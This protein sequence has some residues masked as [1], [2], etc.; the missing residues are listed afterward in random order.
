M[1]FK[2]KVNSQISNRGMDSTNITNKD[3]DSSMSNN[4]S[5][6]KLKGEQ[7]CY[8]GDSI[9]HNCDFERLVKETG[10]YLKTIKAY[11]SVRDEHHHFPNKNFEYVLRREMIEHK[12]SILILQSSSVDIHELAK[13]DDLSLDHKEQEAKNSSYNMLRHALDATKNNKNLK[14]VVIN[15]RIPCYDGKLKQHLMQLGNDELYC[16]GNIYKDD[17]I[18]IGKHELRCDNNTMHL[19]YG[20]Y[21]DAHYDG[22][23]LKGSKGKLSYTISVLTVLREILLKSSLDFHSSTS[24]LTTDPNT[25]KLKSQTLKNASVKIQSNSSAIHLDSVSQIKIKCH[26]NEENGFDKSNEKLQY[27]NKFVLNNPSLLNT[28]SEKAIYTNY[29]IE[30]PLR[31]KPNIKF[32]NKEAKQVITDKYESSLNKKHKQT[33]N[34]KVIG[35]ITNIKTE[36]LF[37]IPNKKYISIDQID[38]TNKN[39]TDNLTNRNTEQLFS[40]PKKKPKCNNKVIMD[41]VQSYSQLNLQNRFEVLYKIDTNTTNKHIINESSSIN[42]NAVNIECNTGKHKKINM[43]DL[44]NKSICKEYPEMEYKNK[45]VIDQS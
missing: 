39:L 15:D 27:S 21:S 29:I 28:L 1:A 38:Q 8:I 45:D 20:R 42:K 17:K 24:S 37:S 14:L 35:H 18:F 34:I 41:S 40:I 9:A 32:T 6:K 23:H 30:Y 10:V 43:L 26:N 3:A 13:R 22:W 11:G 31:Q 4:V 36:P 19:L 25:T 12:P 5:L 16:L 33:N 44:T 2:V 7:M